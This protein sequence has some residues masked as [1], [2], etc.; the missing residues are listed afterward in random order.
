MNGRLVDLTVPVGTETRSP[1]S[2][3]MR[4]ELRRHAADPASGR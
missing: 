2:T 1:P 3:D 4:V